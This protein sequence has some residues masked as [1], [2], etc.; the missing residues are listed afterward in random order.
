M[1]ISEYDYINEIPIT[2]KELYDL[3]WNERLSEVAKKYYIS[4]SG[5]IKKCQKLNIPLPNLKYWIKLKDPTNPPSKIPLPAFSG[6]DV[7]YLKPRDEVEKM[8]ES[9]Q[10][11]LSQ[12]KKEIENDSNVVLKVPAKLLNPDPL[13]AAARDHLYKKEVYHKDQ[14]VIHYIQ[15]SV[16][17]HVSP[18]L[19]KR[20]LCF[21]DTMI[22][23][24]RNRGHQFIN[25]NGHAHVVVYGEDYLISCKERE[26]RVIVKGNY[27]DSSKLEPT[28][29]LSFRLGESYWMKEWTEGKTRIEEQVLK[30]LAGIEYRGLRDQQE[31]IE[32]EKE[33][34]K[35]EKEERIIKALQ[36]RKEKE[37][38]NFKELFKKSRRHEEAEIIRRYIDKLEESAI[39]RNELT[40]ELKNFIR[41]AR[42]KANW[43]D[44]FI[45]AHDELLDE[46]DREELKFKRQNFG[47]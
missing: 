3:V 13:I 4:E 9:I 33:R 15:G 12:I 26:K 29:Y 7:I 30:I 35:R 8:K 14:G 23:A 19:I 25:K 40:D 46:V 24:L 32:R 10:K 17:I 5:L 39:Q 27:Y 43:Y 1:T 45:E 36:E 44:P 11:Q 47:I 20:A 16:G 37:L 41:W 38:A 21:M 31:R 18:G 22:K 6:Y 28:G 2:R 34:L 42:E